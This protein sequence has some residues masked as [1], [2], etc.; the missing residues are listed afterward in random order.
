MAIGGNSGLFINV[1]IGGAILRCREKG[2]QDQ[3]IYIDTLFCDPMNFDTVDAS[4]YLTNQIAQ[5]AFEMWEYSLDQ[6]DYVY[7][8]EDY[9]HVNF[10]YTVIPSTSLPSD[11]VPLGFNHD[12]IEKCVEMGINDAKNVI[13]AGEG[14]HADR[15]YKQ[16]KEA[17]LKIQEEPA[18]YSIQDDDE[19]QE[20]VEVMA[21]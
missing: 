19:N 20:Q 16:F 15:V 2:Y 4:K 10:R 21:L 6:R 7:A 12:N 11:L 13:A 1:D 3:D 17:M 9:P 5:R 14:V 8:R 18:F